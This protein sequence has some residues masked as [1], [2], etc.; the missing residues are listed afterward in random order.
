MIRR[1][2][3]SNRVTYLVR[4]TALGELGYWCEVINNKALSDTAQVE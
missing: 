3:F 2:S 4:S 1:L